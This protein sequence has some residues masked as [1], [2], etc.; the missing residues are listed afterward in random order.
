MSS[1]LKNRPIGLEEARAE[2]ARSRATFVTKFGLSIYAIHAAIDYMTFHDWTTVSIRLGT[3]LAALLIV[4]PLFTTWGQRHVIVFAT[5]A[6]FVCYGGFQTIV[7]YRHAYDSVYADA[8]DLFLPAYCLLLPVTTR[9]A[10]WVGIGMASMSIGNEVVFN[11]KKIVPVNLTI[12]LVNYAIVI[13]LFVAVRHV[14]NR[15][16]ESEFVARAELNR[17]LEDLRVTQGRLVQSE[18]MAAIGRLTGEVAHELNNPLSLISVNLSTIERQAADHSGTS[19]EFQRT[20]SEGLVLVQAGVKQAA[21]VVHNLRQF[22]ALMRKESAAADV[23]EILGI[24]VSLTTGR[25]Q[26]NGI[27]IHREYGSLPRTWCNPQS[28]SQV[29]VNVLQNACEAIEDNGNIWVS[30]QCEGN[31]ITVLVK[32]DGP[33]VAAEVVPHVFEPYYSTKK[34]STGIGLTI[35]RRIIEEHGGTIQIVNEPPGAK[36]S[37]VLPVAPH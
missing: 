17:A 10:L 24:A 23:N 19:P 34:R 21:G 3:A 30:T 26:R 2:L 8:L 37:I 20:L 27:A 32:D 9:L 28:L 12:E 18:R 13:G 35:S 6:F 11:F 15:L 16:W 29:F 25:A 31:A 36:V 22:G 5:V 33:G 7:W 4:C 1:A 14:T